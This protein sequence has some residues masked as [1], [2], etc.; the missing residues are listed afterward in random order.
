MVELREYKHLG[1]SLFVSDELFLPNPTTNRIAKAIDHS[2]LEGKIVFDIGTGVGPLAIWAAKNGARHVYGVDTNSE[3]IDMAKVN[4]KYNNVQEKTDFYVG[5]LFDPLNSMKAD[6]IIGDVS[7]LTDIAGRV[8]GYY[9]ERVEVGGPDGTRNI[10]QLLLA[11]PC[12]LNEGGTLYFPFTPDLADGEKTMRAAE[13]TFRN[14]EHLQ[15]IKFELKEDD[16]IALKAAYNGNLP[17]FMSK[18]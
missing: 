4:A 2:D 5:S 12:Y 14:I 17:A 18:A 10:I 13:E 7:T 16:I 11:A 1:L 9:P 15:P 6:T 8:L 3:Q